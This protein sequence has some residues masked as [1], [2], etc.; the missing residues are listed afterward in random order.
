MPK[1]G[2]LLTANEWSENENGHGSEAS[3]RNLKEK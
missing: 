2:G 3:G 1:P